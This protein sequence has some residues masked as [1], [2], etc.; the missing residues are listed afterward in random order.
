MRTKYVLIALPAA[1][2]RAGPGLEPVSMIT[3]R[4]EAGTATHS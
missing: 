3:L 4:S 1:G 2:I